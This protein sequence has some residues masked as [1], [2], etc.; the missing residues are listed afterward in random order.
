MTLHEIEAV[1]AMGSIEDFARVFPGAAV[2]V[3]TLDTPH[4]DRL[5]T[6][7]RALFEQIPAE[8]AERRAEWYAGRLAAHDALAA[9]GHPEAARASVLRDPEGRPI[10]AGAQVAIS[11]GRTI[12]SAVAA[13]PGAP[14]P[15]VGIDI[16][17]PHDQTR[18][19]RIAE[20]VLRGPEPELARAHP[21]DGL[22]LIWGAR[23]AVAKATHTGMFAFALTRVHATGIERDPRRITTNRPGIEVRWLTLDGGEILVVAGA[24]DAAVGS[25]QAEAR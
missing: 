15:H 19:L 6:A 21:Q 16:V 9:C 8:R 11:H 25:A 3:R 17:D 20:R 5:T 13:L 7:E 4:V 2:A 22:R 24:T 1:C 14:W 12:A 23:E 18:L 10:V